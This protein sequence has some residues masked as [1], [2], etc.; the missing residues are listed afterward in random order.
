MTERPNTTSPPT[1]ARGRRRWHFANAVLDEITLELVVS[2]AKSELERKPL[3]VLIYLLQHA[4]EVCTKDELLTAVWPGRI[5]SET[6]LTKCIGRLRDV[7][8]DEA[9]NIIK[10]AYGFGYRLIAPVRVESGP[11]LQEPRFDFQAGQHP[12]GRPLWSL[13]ERLGAGGHGEAWRARHDKTREQRVFK[14]ALDENSL[15]ALKREITLFRVVNDTL[16]DGAHVVR[17]LDWNL[18]QFPYFIEA[19]YIAGGSLID[20]AQSR[21]GIATIPLPDR[22]EIVARIATALAAVHSVGVLHKDLKPSNVMVRPLAG[23]ASE[24]L[25]GDFG[26]GGILDAEHIERLGITRLGFTRTLAASDLSAATP[27]YLAPEIVAGQPFTVKADIYALGVV[28]YQMIVGDFH[29]LM[30]PGWERDIEDELLREDVAL[31]AEG[32]PD[33]RLADATVLA[34]R[35]RTLEERRKDLVAKREA[36]AKAERARRLL[37]RAQARRFGLIIAFAVLIAGLATST[38]LYMQARRAQHRSDVAAAQSKA[39]TE[40]IGK[41]VFAPVS[42]GTERVKDLSVVEL[43]RRAGE[44]IDSRFT[45]QPEVA[46]ELH[47]VLGRSFTVFYESQLSV[48]HFNRALELGEQLDGAGSESAMRSAA[49]LIRLDYV[50]GHLPK[51]LTRYEAVLKAGTA[52]LDRRNMALL[53]LRQSLAWGYF[54]LGRW[55]DSAKALREVSVDTPAN[56]PGAT[57]FEGH[58]HLYLG[59]VLVALAQPADAEPQLRTA[60]SQLSAALTERHSDVSEARD[61]L[62]RALTDSGK[63]AEAR[64]QLDQAAE[65]AVQWA[66]P[67]TWTIAR[68]RYD[69]ALFYLTMDEPALAQPLLE[70]IV[71]YQDTNTGINPDLD[72]TGTVRRALAEAYLRQAKYDEALTTLQ[73]AVLVSTAADGATHPDTQS[74]KLT[75][76]EAFLAAGRDADAQQTLTAPPA[77]DLSALPQ[78]H[79]YVAQLYRVKGLLAL[80]ARDR[81]RARESLLQAKAIYEALYG[82]AHWRSVRARQELR[83][84]GG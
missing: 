48:T 66:P 79:P 75:L 7:L 77:F 28:F 6:A 62:G 83:N 39:V 2:G 42:S 32:N 43:L 19:E 31:V 21:G 76:A 15:A 25:L 37:E 23:S 35:L 10:T 54:K 52:R 60:I 36:V 22:L 68:P 40:F 51:T 63:L 34:K 49:A 8:Q 78:H 38:A 30:S 3:E 1:G 65:L 24:I 74:I 80:H 26:S 72:H 29:K 64:I 57:E 12:P 55:T 46:S 13:T 61:A 71:A 53:S 50:L 69:K 33:V 82:S 81:T 47:Y 67:G 27:L 9:Q 18:E 56:V 4:G 16:G 20:W 11:T 70:A 44:Q 5:L 58:T 59:L 17:L 41:D 14:F 73:K 45:A 84:A